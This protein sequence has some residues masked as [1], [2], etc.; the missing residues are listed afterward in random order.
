MEVRVLGKFIPFGEQHN[1][2]EDSI[3]AC[4]QNQQPIFLHK[5][6]TKKNISDS[7]NF[8]YRLYGSFD[9][10]AKES[11]YN[12]NVDEELF[13]EDNLVI[14][15]RG[16][17]LQKS[18][19]FTEPVLQALFV[20]FDAT[21]TCGKGL[22][23]KI[24][25]RHDRQRALF[26]LL[27]DYAKVYFP[28]GQNFL[29]RVPSP[30]R[31]AWAMDVGVILQCVV[32]DGSYQNV[33]DF[34]SGSLPTL[35]S[36]LD[37]LEEIKPLTIAEK[38]T[39]DGS[40][41]N[42]RGKTRSFADTDEVVIF[43]NDRGGEGNSILVTLNRLTLRH[44][45]YKYIINKKENNLKTRSDNFNIPLTF[46]RSR[47]NSNARVDALQN[48]DGRISSGIED[49]FQ[50][51]E[52]RNSYQSLDRF[53]YSDHDE[54][55]NDL[56]IKLD[57][58]SDVFLELIWTESIAKIE[59]FEASDVF[60]AHDYDGHEILCIFSKES[61]DFMALDVCA[62]SHDLQ[63][64]AKFE[65]KIG[66]AAPVIATRSH[67]YDILF[68]KEVGKVSTLELWIGY[69]KLIPLNL[70]Y[71]AIK[72][73]LEFCGS[74][75]ESTR[76]DAHIPQEAFSHQL[77][78]KYLI[79]TPTYFHSNAPIIGLRDYVHNR[80]NFVFSNTIVRVSL[81]F[82]PNSKLARS[83]LEALSYVLP[84]DLYFDFKAQYMSFQYGGDGK[85]S[86]LRR[87]T[88]WENFVTV[89]FSFLHLSGQNL[90]DHRYQESL[91]ESE[92]SDWDFMLSSTK[93]AKFNFN[94]HYQCLRPSITTENCSIIKLFEKSRRLY[95]AYFAFYHRLEKKF[96][97]FLPSILLSL[98]LVYQDLKLDTLLQKFIND[99]VPLLIQLAYFLGWDRYIDYYQRDYGMNQIFRF[100]KVV[101]T[102]SKLPNDHP[103]F[104]PPD[105]FQ[106]IL[107]CI[108]HGMRKNQCFLDVKD[109]S[110]IFSVS[111]IEEKLIHDFDCC[112]RTRKINSIYKALINEGER[113]MIL[114]MVKVGYS[115]KYIDS[116]P[117]GVA[118]PL[119]EAI[120]KCREEPP[121][122]W[123]GEAYILVGREDLAELSC[124]IPVGYIHTRVNK[125]E[126]KPRDILQIVEPT[127][128]ASTSTS[129]DQQ[130][131]NTGTEI[132]NR[133]VSD[134]R[135]GN[136]K[137][138][139]EVQRL[140][141]SC[142]VVKADM[143]MSDLGVQNE[144][145]SP[146]MLEKVQ[147]QCLKNFSQPVG[148]GILTYG[149]A[150]PIATEPFPIPGFSTSI[151]VSPFN[152]SIEVGRAIRLPESIEWP[153]F[154]D[155][156]AAGLRIPST[157][158]IEGSWISLNKPKDLNNSHA[159][160]LLG[161]G[162]NGHLRSMA[163]WQAVDYL[164]KT[165]K[166][167]ITTIALVLG[168]PASYIGTMNTEITKFVAVH[169]TAMFPPKSTSLNVSPLVQTASILGCGLLYMETCN[170]YMSQIMLAEISTRALKTSDSSETDFTEG[171]SLAAGLALGLINL[172]HG[173]N[174]CESID[175]DLFKEL[176]L[177]I[178]SGRGSAK[179]PLSVNESDVN[180]TSPGATIALGFLY[181]KTG[182][183]SVANKISI[184]EAEFFLDYMRPDFLLVRTLAKNLI[185]WD[186]I[187]STQS[188]VENHIPQY[189][190][191]KLTR[192]RELDCENLE[193][194]R[195]SYYY[196]LAGACLSMSLK[197]A[198]S[199]DKS[200]LKCLLYY[201]DLFM[202]LE[203]GRSIAPT[204][205]ENITLSAIKICLNVLATC[206]SIVAAG[207]GNLEVLRRIRKL[208]KQETDTTNSSSISRSYGTH[209]MTSMALG[210]LFLGGG[211]F[212]LS[213]SN[214]AIAGLVCSLFPRYPI[215]T[216]DNRAHLQAFR[217]LWVL[218]VEPRCL[219]LRDIETREVCH[220]PVKIVFKD[221]YNA[222]VVTNADGG[223][224][225]QSKVLACKI[226]IRKKRGIRPKV[227]EKFDPT[228]K[229]K[230]W[231]FNLC[232]GL[233]N[234]FTRIFPGG[235]P[236]LSTVNGQKKLDFIGIFSSDPQVQA[237]SRY[238]CEDFSVNADG[239]DKDLV[240]FCNVILSECLNADKVEAIQIYLKLYQI[241][242]SLERISGLD[243]WNIMLT[244]EY[245]K[246]AS[247]IERR[248]R[249]QKDEFLIKQEYISSL[250][251]VLDRFFEVP[252]FI[253]GS[254][255][256][257][258]S[259]NDEYFVS[260][261]RSYFTNFEFPSAERLGGEGNRDRFLKY[262]TS[263][264]IYYEVPDKYILLNVTGHVRELKR[265]LSLE[266]VND[267][268]AVDATLQVLSTLWPNLSNNTL[269]A[270]LY[271]MA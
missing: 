205:D 31:R 143:P 71:D 126:S 207:T 203:S 260:L 124:G 145:S 138:L 32:G 144:E 136:D 113:S 127:N 90:P 20:W 29:I 223:K 2:R 34:P 263:W 261:L 125:M 158:T 54:I 39:I 224:G 172:G 218:A 76:K 99:L 45:I 211:N 65:F 27:E 141:Q 251:A 122:N 236:L 256:A 100:E 152:S 267:A 259:S 23:S 109:I 156:V 204:F 171:Y 199:A 62:N 162:L 191:R 202:G 250:R 245:Y 5:R 12:G 148:R 165:P 40:K 212:T 231:T 132:S 81:N 67:L 221:L 43:V 112:S 193:S 194:I 1:R 22:E 7:A 151:K 26:V 52:G 130:Q 88:E 190:K 13:V 135:F 101:I 181:L 246:N 198:G 17:I 56:R 262:L 155:G 154:H 220:V 51:G 180:I 118:I 79:S 249:R 49:S 163:T 174:A 63:I 150:T 252:S 60:I 227:L 103:L 228:R 142:N 11:N 257:V 82:I 128:S 84:T 240:T 269:R 230:D 120:R 28:D 266:K 182:K 21:E 35:Y 137:R 185:M 110:K 18:F 3:G 140:L 201:L 61:K 255:S 64:Y 215:E 157:I 131:D 48:F 197:Y 46:I 173:D 94:T 78:R 73:G 237:F 239:G 235:K 68:V 80:L 248:D 222:E 6:A 192:S 15:S 232:R 264:L 149:T 170:R 195:R 134:L 209:M 96:I 188:W 271:C 38:I 66:A 169:V 216:Y 24:T 183:V 44:S 129:Q 10:S 70:D 8:N 75:E 206:T 92:K 74:R 164:M 106:W 214:K 234:L 200:A 19:R 37:P 175:L 69:G 265:K 104:T 233:R 53:L 86:D 95:Y 77:F 114:E 98:H 226:R 167:D 189:M 186:N 187:Q 243:L 242:K 30:V 270:I 50:S 247:K 139:I 47:S 147:V 229:K 238:L 108:R 179:K 225:L 91:D 102:E 268:T 42:T 177:Y 258:A 89:L 36:L 25:S 72:Y 87:G 107:E 93:H 119:R 213:T 146:Q 168:L 196:I 184:P 219:V 111:K 105:I 58:D 116:L 85:F 166:H 41:M 117:F 33:S 123:P 217:H 208:H 14:W 244:L 241:Q 153:E 83:C 176:R 55:F 254:G 160:F 161:L 121:S 115:I 178:D 210:F 16:N 59:R 253:T 159:G 97:S 4:K 57:S 133:E 9:R